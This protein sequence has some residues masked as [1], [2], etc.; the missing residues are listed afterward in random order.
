MRLTD[1]FPWLGGFITALAA[2]LGAYAALKAKRI[3]NRNVT[4][5]ETQQSLNAQNVLLDRYEKRITTLEE[6]V[7]LSSTKLESAM[8]AREEAIAAHQEC[9]SKLAAIE[10]RITEM[11]G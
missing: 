3:D 5:Q 10:A 9:E 2:L 11:G 1:V 7:E 6:K 8:A 4:R